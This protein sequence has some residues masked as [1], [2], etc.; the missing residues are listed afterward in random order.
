MLNVYY[1]R[2]LLLPQNYLAE[3]IV[4][5]TIFVHPNI[6]YNIIPWIKAEYFFLECHKIIYTHLLIMA[7]KDQFNITEFIYTTGKTTILYK[8]GGINKI[9]DLMKQSQIFIISLSNINLYI[10]EL[11]EN[12]QH[13]YI[14]RL[15]IQY[16]YNIIKLAYLNKISHHNLYNKAS[17]Y[18]NITEKKIPKNH[19]KTLQELLI[20]FLLNIK[21]KNKQK[22]TSLNITKKTDVLLKSGFKD[23]DKLIFNLFGG[24]LIILAGR[25]STGK[26]SLAI[27]I[28]NNIVNTTKHSIYIFSLEMSNKQIL[29]KFISINTNIPLKTL[30]IKNF[31]KIECKQIINTCYK[32]T[33]INIYID[34][35]PNISIDYIEYTAKLLKKENVTINLII[36]DYLQ[37]IQTNFASTINRSQELSYITR[38]LKLLSQYLNVPIIILSQLNRNIENRN[39]KQPLL[40]DLKDSGCIEISNNF[41]IIDK[42]NHINIKTFINYLD[43]ININKNIFFELFSYIRLHQLNQKKY[44]LLFTQYIFKCILDTNIHIF[45]TYNHKYIYLY[46]WIN[47]Y[48]LYEKLFIKSIYQIQNTRLKCNKYLKNIQF[49]NYSKCYDFQIQNYFH[50]ICNHII[51]HNSIEQDADIVM[52]IHQEQKNE[53]NELINTNKLLNITVCKNRNGPIGAVKLLFYENTTLF[54]DNNYNISQNNNI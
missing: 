40:S 44:I 21:Y 1:D 52:M 24:D 4:L 10:E 22:N 2:H 51:L 17:S 49:N 19:I 8:I 37:L 48:F 23:L 32:L 18:L 50:F 13:N 12:I 5:G 26:T 42:K 25:P 20:E 36:I 41:H 3:E 15:L 30:L 31:T 34:D 11:I 33:D 29:N 43:K 47:T 45:V 35:K 38:K 46:E 53:Y 16:G 6:I 27:N 39:N 28:A 7:Q 14:K 54:K 9:W